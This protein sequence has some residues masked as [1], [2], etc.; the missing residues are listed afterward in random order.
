MTRVIDPSRAGEKGS[1]AAAPV[2]VPSQAAAH[3][4]RQKP[5]NNRVPVD[6]ASIGAA[7]NEQMQAEMQQPLD[8]AAHV[9]TKH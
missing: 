3:A 8:P 7:T 2:P 6:L 1:V 4:N 9:P 5:D